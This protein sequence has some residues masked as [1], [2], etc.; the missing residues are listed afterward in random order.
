MT[1]R[2]LEVYPGCSFVAIEWISHTDVSLEYVERSPDPWYG[3]TETSIDIDREMARSIIEFL[4][5]EFCLP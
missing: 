2:R 3:D 5:H 1:E 4:R